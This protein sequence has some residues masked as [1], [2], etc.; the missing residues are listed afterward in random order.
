VEPTQ[1]ILTALFDL[2]VSQQTVVFG[3][4]FEFV[5]FARV[6]GRLRGVTEKEWPELFATE[7]SQYHRLKRHNNL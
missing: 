2:I 7:I 1:A 6:L 3:L 4:V 5:I